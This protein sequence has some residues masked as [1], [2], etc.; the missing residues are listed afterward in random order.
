MIFNVANVQLHLFCIFNEILV[1][2]I[3]LGTC[4]LPQIIQ[5]FL[6]SS[7]TCTCTA[8]AVLFSQ[9]FQFVNAELLIIST[10][11]SRSVTIIFSGTQLI[12]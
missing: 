12:L 5:A 7:N 9:T 4:Y 1:A 2:V 11:P 10:Q 3:N 8:L 6:Y